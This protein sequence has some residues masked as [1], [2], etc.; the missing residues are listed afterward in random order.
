MANCKKCNAEIIWL[1]QHGVEDAKGNPIDA[2]GTPDGNL[3][4]NRE[5]GVYRIATGN[6]KEIAK[7]NNKKLYVSHFSTCPNAEEFRGTK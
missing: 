2:V 1:K 6:E 7:L 4:I 5:L 3:V